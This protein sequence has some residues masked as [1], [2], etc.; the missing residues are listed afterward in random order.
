MNERLLFIGKS[1]STLCDFL[2]IYNNLLKTPTFTNLPCC[3]LLS[4]KF[5][6]TP[7]P[8]IQYCVTAVAMYWLF[9]KAV[10]FVAVKPGNGE[11][12]LFNVVLQFPQHTIQANIS[13][14]NLW[15]ER[16]AQKSQFPLFSTIR[17][18]RFND[19]IYPY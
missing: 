10:E 9:S 19:I 3:R 7:L 6:K 12:T 16:E 14:S 11:L 5:Q 8:R 17:V 18:E 1:I 13:S 15:I 4:C 2:V